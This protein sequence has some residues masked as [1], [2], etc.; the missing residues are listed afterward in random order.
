MGEYHHS[1]E[2]MT[3][4]LDKLQETLRLQDKLYLGFRE[5]LRTISSAL[6]TSVGVLTD[7]QKTLRDTVALQGAPDTSQDDELPTTSA[8][9]RGQD[10]PPQDQHTSTPSPA[11]GQPPRKRALRS[12][13]RT[14]QDGKTTARK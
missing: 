10:A 6:G 9:A 1:Q 4:V 12:R 8:G 13:N 7:I 11:D 14:E 2:T 5:E 3:T